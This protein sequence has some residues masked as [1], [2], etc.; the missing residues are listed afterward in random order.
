AV[1]VLPPVYDSAEDFSEGLAAARIKGRTGYIDE[2]GSI[3]VKPAYDQ[4]YPFSEGLAMVRNGDYWGYID[5]TGQVVIPLRYRLA[6][7]FHE[8]VA[9]VMMRNEEGHRDQLGF[10]APVQ[11]PV[12][13]EVYISD[14]TIGEAPAPEAVGDRSWLFLKHSSQFSVLFLYGSRTGSEGSLT[15]FDIAF[16]FQNF[17][18]GVVRS[19]VCGI[20]ANG[21]LQRQ[22]CAV[23]IAL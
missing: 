10:I 8:E 23:K 20:K 14:V 16:A 12:R 15:A 5:K 4:G 22:F 21:R 7:D 18:E 9:V 17:A 6:H 1:F 11:A 3:I 13:T 19:R 2:S